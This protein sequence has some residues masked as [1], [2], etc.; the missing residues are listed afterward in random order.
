MCSSAQS[1]YRNEFLT[2][3]I[4]AEAKFRYQSFLSSPILLDIFTFREILGPR[5][6]VENTFA[7]NSSQSL[8]NFKVLT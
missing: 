6:S 7:R 1:P 3:A 8:S 5:L 2:I 4:K